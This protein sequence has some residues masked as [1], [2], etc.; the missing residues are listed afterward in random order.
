MHLC[1][2]PYFNCFFLYFYLKYLIYSICYFFH[3][4]Q[5]GKN[6]KKRCFLFSYAP[7]KNDSGY[8]GFLSLLLKGLLAVIT[9]TLLVFLLAVR[10]FFKFYFPL[11]LFP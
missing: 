8:A 4:F 3:K 2:L 9:S 1:V 5:L 10:C 11:N 6:M 7:P